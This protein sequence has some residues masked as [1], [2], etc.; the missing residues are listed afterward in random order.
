MCNRSSMLFDT[1]AKSKFYLRYRFVLQPKTLF[2]KIALL[3]GSGLN[4]A[5][6][7]SE[8]GDKMDSDN[9]VELIESN[10]EQLQQAVDI[11]QDISDKAYRHN[12]GP[13]FSSGI[14]KHLRHILGFY[15]QF[16]IGWQD[17][18][19]YDSRSRDSQLENDR[20]YGIRKIREV[21]DQLN[22][23]GWQKEILGQRLLVKN[24]EHGFNNDLAAFTQ[25]T[26]ERELQFLRFHT[27][28]HF[29]IISM[30]L[31]IQGIEPPEELGF[32]PSTLRY[33]ATHG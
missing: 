30:I 3:T 24:D 17:R 11:L 1:K 29:A 9:R 16:F 10:I 26:I 22:R 12:D 27:V 25:S 20:V 28:H 7:L 5:A 13:Y 8:K 2:E 18:V 14:G 23:M 4:P 33:L 32:A 21:I 19:D 31:R 6:Y 15:E